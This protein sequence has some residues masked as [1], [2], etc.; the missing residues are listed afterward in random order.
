MPKRTSDTFPLVI[1]GCLVLLA[2][3]LHSIYED[4]LKEAVLKRLSTFMGIGEAELVSRLAEMAVPVIGAVAVGWIIYFYLKAHL[5]TDL[6][7]V[8]RL[9]ISFLES[10]PFVYDALKFRCYRFR[11]KNETDVLIGSCKA[12]MESAY[13]SDGTRIVS[14]PFSLRRSFSHDEIFTLRG[15]EEIFIDLLAVPLDPQYANFP[16]KIAELGA[17]DWPQFGN[18]GAVFPNETTLFTIQVLSNA[19]PARLT[20]KYENDGREWRVIR[21]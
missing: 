13:K 21:T 17:Q 19:P 8:P 7:A 3:F 2:L 12:Q 15:G 4:L 10:A 6:P 16:A 1:G 18:G 9:S 11:V 5:S 14:I 20:L